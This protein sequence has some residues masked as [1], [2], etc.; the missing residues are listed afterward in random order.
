MA[1]EPKEPSSVYVP[2]KK[3][4]MTSYLVEHG[5][6]QRTASAATRELGPKRTSEIL[7][8]G[9]PDLEATI[10]ECEVA[11]KHKTDQTVQSEAF[12]QALRDLQIMKSALR[13]VLAPYK[14]AL[15]LSVAV[16]EMHRE[17]H[18]GFRMHSTQ[19]LFGDGV[20]PQ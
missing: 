19:E 16:L 3:S 4:E 7:G 13:E 12:K 14:A 1:E 11:M 9:I 17:R 20:E 10:A 8:L 6:E 5:F 18:G 2:T 15:S